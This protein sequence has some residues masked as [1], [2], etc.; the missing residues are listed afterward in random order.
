M[1]T[2]HL[3]T[4]LTATLTLAPLAAFA[5]T[6][7]KAKASHQTH[8]TTGTV[9]SIDATKLVISRPNKK[10]A[11]LSFQLNGSTRRDG[12]IVPGA[13]VSVRYQDEAGSHVAT[14]VA[15]RPASHVAAHK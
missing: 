11:E 6:P 13:P 10:K 4:L 9:K 3:V 8:A 15:V 14:A 2:L 7:V 12:S 5:A 1:R